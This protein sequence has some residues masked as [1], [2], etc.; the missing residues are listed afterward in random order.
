MIG[1]FI[2]ILHTNVACSPHILNLSIDKF[3]HIALDNSWH[4]PTKITETR[5][6]DV[7][8]CGI[9]RHHNSIY[10]LVVKLTFNQDHK[11]VRYKTTRSLEKDI[12]CVRQTYHPHLQQ[13]ITVN[14][15][16]YSHRCENI[17]SNSV[18]RE[19]MYALEMSVH[20]ETHLCY[21]VER[22]NNALFSFTWNYPFHKS[23]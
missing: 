10:L 5:I 3:H 7:F 20:F 2:P 19:V 1:F 4:W 14:P 6:A 16:C 22:T 8:E 21:P 11:S 17:K 15:L 13:E 12:W 18:I 23:S 9:I